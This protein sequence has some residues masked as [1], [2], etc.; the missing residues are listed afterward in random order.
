MGK[1]RLALL[2]LVSRSAD[3]IRCFKTHRSRCPLNMNA[4][5][6]FAAM[7]A[8]PPISTTCTRARDLPATSARATKRVARRTETKGAALLI[9]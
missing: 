2:L 6:G 4:V 8:I 5:Y 1:A 3:H 7:A 9:G